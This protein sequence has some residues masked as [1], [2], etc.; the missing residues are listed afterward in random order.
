MPLPQQMV[1]WRA[2]QNIVRPVTLTF[3]YFI[4]LFISI[5]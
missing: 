3:I 4:Y 2:I 5:Q 1:I